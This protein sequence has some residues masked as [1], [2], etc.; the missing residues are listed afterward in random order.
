MEVKNR[1]TYGIA[2]PLLFTF[3]V[4]LLNS[5]CIYPYDDL[6]FSLCWRSSKIFHAQKGQT[7]FAHL[8]LRALLHRRPVWLGS[9]RHLCTY[10][11]LS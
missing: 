11:S 5:L 7:T 10:Q 8:V 3:L 9:H 2:P 4:L 6:Y 1:L